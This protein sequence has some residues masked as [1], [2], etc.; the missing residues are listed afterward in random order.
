MG[1]REGRFCAEF[2]ALLLGPRARGAGEFKSLQEVAIVDIEDGTVD[3]GECDGEKLVF[4]LD[5]C[6]VMA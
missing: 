5:D 3:A 4:D 6:R 2:G 1:S